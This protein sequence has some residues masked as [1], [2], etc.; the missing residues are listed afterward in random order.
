VRKVI[1]DFKDSEAMRVKKGTG[2][3]LDLM[4]H[5]EQMGQR[6]TAE[7]LETWAS[8]V[9]KVNLAFQECP[10]DLG[11]KVAKEMM[12]FQVLVHLAHL[13]S[14]GR[15]EKRAYQVCQEKLALLEAQVR[16]IIVNTLKFEQLSISSTLVTGQIGFP[17]QKG[18]KGM[19]G[20][21][22]LNG[23]KGNNGNPGP[24]GP[25]GP[26]G[27]PGP[28]GRDGEKGTRGPE[29]TTGSPG[30]P[31]RPGVKGDKGFPGRDGLKGFPGL[32]GRPGEN[33][34]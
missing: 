9:L 17:G 19:A 8:L 30:M 31:G 4:D 7:L 1:K 20:L 11:I 16:N 26:L 22:G 10:A 23:I 12:E 13:D 24:V 29:G 21:P 14:Q 5:Q 27:P 34:Q 33:L 6:E 28:S 2:V 32:P 15:K 18:G 25:R 3:H